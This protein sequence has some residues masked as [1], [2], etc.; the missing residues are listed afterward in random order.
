MGVLSDLMPDQGVQ[1]Q[2]L[3]IF[4]LINT[5]LFFVQSN[6]R[7]GIRL[8]RF[9]TRSDNGFKFLIILLT[10]GIRGTSRPL[11]N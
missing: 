5:F 8:T 9:D 10:T 2:K 7:S 4:I 6:I 11:Q 1:E 3:K